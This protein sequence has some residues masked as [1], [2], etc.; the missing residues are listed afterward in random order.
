MT[1]EDRYLLS[2]LHELNLACGPFG[3]AVVEDSL[4]RADELVMAYRFVRVADR[5]LLRA[6]STAVP[7][8][9]E[10][11]EGNGEPLDGPVPPL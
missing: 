6:C 10:E 4:S 11:A 1:D 3:L 8:V 9:V 5:I 7:Q 2:L